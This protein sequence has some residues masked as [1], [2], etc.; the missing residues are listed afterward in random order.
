MTPCPGKISQVI[1]M[2]LARPR[3]RSNSRFID[4]RDEIFSIFSLQR[5]KPATEYQI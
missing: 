2:P 3:D 4:L 5:V 1:D